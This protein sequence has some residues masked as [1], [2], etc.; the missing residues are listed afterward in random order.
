MP[1]QIPNIPRMHESTRSRNVQAMYETRFPIAQRASRPGPVRKMPAGRQMIIEPF[2]D[3]SGR[4]SRRFLQF[5]VSDSN[6]S[7][8]AVAL[9]SLNTKNPSA[10][11]LARLQSSGSAVGELLMWKL[12]KWAAEQGYKAITLHNATYGNKRVSFA[13][14]SNPYD[15]KLRTSYYDRFLSKEQIERLQHNH[16]GNWNAHASVKQINLPKSRR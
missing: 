3:A 12:M 1:S 14:N 4:V 11:H 10:L 5:V 16:T 2:T 6:R 15:D 9:V 7:T 13:S 8:E